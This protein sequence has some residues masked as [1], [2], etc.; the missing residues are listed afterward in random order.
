VARRAVAGRLVEALDEAHAVGSS[1]AACTPASVVVLDAAAPT[2]GGAPS[3]TL[4]GLGTGAIDAG[5]P[6]APSERPYVSP[7]QLA[8]AS[9]TAAATSTG[10]PR[11]CTTRS[12]ASRPPRRPERRAPRTTRRRHAARTG[13]ARRARRRAVGGP[14]RAP[15]R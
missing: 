5:D 9:R 15:R 7:E 11:C 3:V 12:P 4:I 2:R 1:T 14:R 8:G 10:S 13:R 6:V